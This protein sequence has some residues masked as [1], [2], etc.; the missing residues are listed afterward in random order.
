MHV[1]TTEGNLNQVKLALIRAY[2]VDENMHRMVFA[3]M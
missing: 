1:G 3:V 2:H